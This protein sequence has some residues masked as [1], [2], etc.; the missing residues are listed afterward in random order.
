MMRRAKY[1]NVKS[2]TDGDVFEY[3]WIVEIAQEDE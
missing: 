1:L 2:C 3:L